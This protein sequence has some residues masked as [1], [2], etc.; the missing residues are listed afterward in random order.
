MHSYVHTCIFTWL[1]LCLIVKKKGHPVH[2][3]AARKYIWIL[4]LQQA[5][6][7]QWLSECMWVREREKERDTEKKITNLYIQKYL[8]IACNKCLAALENAQTN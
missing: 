3:F 4:Y 8:T 2:V 7:K 5:V 6:H 1:D